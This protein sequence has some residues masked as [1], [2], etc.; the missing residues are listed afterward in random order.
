MGGLGTVGQEPPAYDTDYWATCYRAASEWS[1]R[2]AAGAPR[3]VLAAANAFSKECVQPY[4]PPE[5]NVSTMLDP[6][7]PRLPV[8]VDYYLSTTRWGMHQL[9]PDSTVVHRVE[10]GGA[11]LCL[12]KSDRAD[13][14]LFAH[15]NPRSATPGGRPHQLL[16]EETIRDGN[17]PPPPPTAAP[18]PARS[19]QPS[20][21]DT[22]GAPY[23][24]PQ[25]VEAPT[26]DPFKSA[27]T[28]TTDLDSKESMAHKPLGVPRSETVEN[29]EQKYVVDPNTKLQ[30]VDLPS[31]SVNDVSSAL[32]YYEVANK[33][34]DTGRFEEAIQRFTESI[35]RD[36]SSPAAYNNLGALLEA[37]QR[38]AE[39]IH[40]YEL[41]VERHPGF[42]LGYFNL[43]S[44]LYLGLADVVADTDAAV[45]K[46][47]ADATSYLQRS[48]DLNPAYFPAWSNLGDAKRAAN[49]IAGAV[50][51]Y[52]EALA[53]SP[54]YEVALNN[55]GNALKTAG[56]LD[57]AAMQYELAIRASVTASPLMWSNLG[58]VYME[59]DRLQDALYAYSNATSADPT[60]VS[61]YTNKGRIV[62]A[63][64]QMIIW[65]DAT[66]LFG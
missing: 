59:Q 52:L 46:Q 39:A 12:V 27:A 63:M 33:M 7:A 16:T 65:C 11:T 37:Q 48:V 55:L 40:I 10:R 6:V 38:V 41:A 17:T 20:P 45:V 53:R 56:R 31:G 58:A 15:A 5:W 21:D 51:C 60:Y 29:H 18:V 24:A 34:R 19:P 25:N 9:Y 43:G 22:P 66:D 57:E 23:S 35:N 28:V 36:N 54:T 62:S 30:P 64:L 42:A 26:G 8:D 1:V 47:L 2:H 3:H 14:Q 13:A 32:Y 61:A 49:D 4:L 44:R 50:S